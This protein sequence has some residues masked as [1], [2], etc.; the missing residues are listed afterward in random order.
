M[1][2]EDKNAVI[3]GAGRGIG[4]AIALAFAREGANI[5]LNDV[6][7]PDAD[8]VA[9]EVRDLGR[10]AFVVK[11]DVSDYDA[12]EKM[13]NRFLSEM[14][15]IDILINNAG[16]ASQKKFV[17][18]EKEEWDWLIGIVMGGAFNCCRTLINPMMEQKYGRIINISSI[19][20]FCGW[21]EMAHYSAA[22]SGL[23]AFTRA[24]A[25]EVGQF[26][27]TVN[28]VA[29]GNIATPMHKTVPQEVIDE[30]VRMTPVGRLGQPEEIAEV[31][32]YLASEKADYMTGQVL[33]PNGGILI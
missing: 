23:I 14:G 25:K 7:L 17:E 1:E 6:N 32:V 2:L 10:K 27:I 24:L 22:K 28:T 8:H 21:P 29:P 13:M 11:T 5:G 31:C 18:M 26:G 4:R 12:V 20:G 15:G 9:K 33:S 3:T 16:V 30:I 19:F